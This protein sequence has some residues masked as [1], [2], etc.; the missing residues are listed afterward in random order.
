MAQKEPALSMEQSACGVER[1]RGS[2][3]N[4]LHATSLTAID[5]PERSV[6]RS[7]AQL[8]NE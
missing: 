8:D 1:L 6:P 3:S 7:D 2:S 5:L 4:P